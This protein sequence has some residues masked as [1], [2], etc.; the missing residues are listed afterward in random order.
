MHPP[1]SNGINTPSGSDTIISFR[2]A[3]LATISILSIVKIPEPEDIVLP[4]KEKP[5][6]ISDPVET[7]NPESPA[8]P[9]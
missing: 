6:T 7:V 9:P 5:I 4:S 2:Q 1:C 3:S 8:A